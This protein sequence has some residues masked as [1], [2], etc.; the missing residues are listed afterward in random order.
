MA[1]ELDIPLA[2]HPSDAPRP[3]LE[4]LNHAPKQVFD[5]SVEIPLFFASGPSKRGVGE[6]S[7]PGWARHPISIQREA[8]AGVS[9]GGGGMGMRGMEGDGYGES[10]ALIQ[11]QGPEQGQGFWR[12]E[13][14]ENMK[15]R[16]DRIRGELTSEW[17][18]RGRE[19]R[20]QRKRR[21]GG[22]DDE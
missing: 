20:K 13:T 16:W 11:G 8:R 18:R 1:D 4:L 2:P 12:T 9:S 21:G 5:D 14:D 6:T 3:E 19:A 10:E 7:R 15:S 17:K 22:A